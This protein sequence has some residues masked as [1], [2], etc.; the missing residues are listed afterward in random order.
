[1]AKRKAKRSTKKTVNKRTVAR[2][3]R[4][5]RDGTAAPVECLY[6]W[7]ISEP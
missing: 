2:S 6:P 3:P 7:T 1:M 5:L 4:E